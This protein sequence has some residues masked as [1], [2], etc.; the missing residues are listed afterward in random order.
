M[1]SRE[2]KGLS[3]VL[4]SEIIKSRQHFLRITLPDTYR[5]F[6]RNDITDD[7][8]MGYASEYGFRAGTSS[9]F[10]FYDLDMDTVTKLRIHP[11]A[12]M[13]GTFRDY[14]KMDADEAY[15]HIVKLVDAV[16]KVNG[17]FISTILAELN[18]LST[19]SFNL[20]TAVFPFAVL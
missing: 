12:Y 1:L 4:H 18:N 19:C 10:L 5:E 8:S 9:S 20:K 3:M 16:K 14:K 6:I 11:F 2:I 7:Y 13:D 17:T 15:M